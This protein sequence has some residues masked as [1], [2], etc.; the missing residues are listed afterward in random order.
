MTILSTELQ[1]LQQRLRH[2]ANERIA[3]IAHELH[4]R[5]EQIPDNVLEG[6]V[7]QD[8]FT[9]PFSPEIGGAGL[10]AMGMVIATEELGRAWFAAGALPARNWMAALM[11]DKFGT[12][13]Q[14]RRWLPGVV[15]GRLQCAHSATEPGAG[16]DAANI[17]VRATRMGNDYRIDGLKRWCTHANRADLILV[18]CRTGDAEK[19][20]EGISLLVVEKPRGED[21]VAPSLTARRIETIGYHGMKTYELTFNHHVVPAA[22]LLGGEEGRGFRQLMGCYEMVRL[23]FAFRCIGLAQAAFEASIDYA[24]TRM[25]F[26]KPISQFQLIRAKLADMATQ[27]ETARQ[28]GYAVASKYDAGG[29]LDLEAGMAKLFA[30]EMAQR[31]CQEAMQVHGGNSMDLS[32]PV[33]RF[34][35]DSSLCTVGEG[36]SEIQREVIARRILGERG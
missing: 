4:L 29:R 5:G 16:S 25:Q 14:K 23:Q 31:V 28:L 36:T 32:F 34:W 19:K 17:Q 27:V 2:F 11:L 9:L 24:K 12:D 21:F 33:N 35:R 26:G 6:M 13:D 7:E 1:R 10:G 3:P 8:V 30:S 20:H 18:F 15:S 22:N